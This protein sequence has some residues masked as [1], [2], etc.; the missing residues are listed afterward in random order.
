[1]LSVRLKRVFSQGQDP[2]LQL[3]QV[4][5]VVDQACQPLRLVDDDLHVF[6]GVLPGQVRITSP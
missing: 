2:C 4:Q 1:M 5:Q 3:G 6:R